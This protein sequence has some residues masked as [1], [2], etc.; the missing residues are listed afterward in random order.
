MLHLFGIFLCI[1]S[2][3]ILYPFIHGFY[4]WLDSVSNRSSKF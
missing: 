3:F 2:A 4:C 1:A